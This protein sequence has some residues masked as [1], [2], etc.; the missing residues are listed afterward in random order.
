MSALACVRR[1]LKNSITASAS[2]CATIGTT[3]PRHQPAF[4]RRVAARP[5]V[6][7]REVGDPVRRAGVQCVA[8]ER[9]GQLMQAH[10]IRGGDE[11]REARRIGVVPER[12]AGRL[13][14]ARQDRDATE[15]PVQVGSE[16]VQRDVERL[17]RSAA[18]V[19][20]IGQSAQQPR[21]RMLA[22]ERRDVLGRLAVRV[23]E[24]VGV[25]TQHA[26]HGLERMRE[27]DQFAARPFARRLARIAARDR[28]GARGKALQRRAHRARERGAEHGRQRQRGQHDPG[29][30]P[31]GGF[32]RRMEVLVVR[33]DDQHCGGIRR[34]RQ[35]PHVAAVAHAR[36]R[37]RAGLGSK[38]DGVARGR[39]E[40]RI[41][42][43][44]RGLHARAVHERDVGVVRIGDAIELVDVEPALSHGNARDAIAR[45]PA[46][47]RE[48]HTVPVRPDERL[49]RVAG[50]EQ[51]ALDVIRRHGSRAAAY[52]ASHRPL[53]GRARGPGVATARD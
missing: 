40:R 18:A 21:A 37:R 24:P 14:L 46:R 6:Q 47:H 8:E 12:V 45:Q 32:E 22:R 48:S 5:V 42:P 53:Q 36:P 11:R 49:R 19:G 9:A 27:P 50:V 15:R 2:P 44:D 3:K 31:T 25:V 51:A 34:Q 1:S 20:G 23:L 33:H 26:G 35:R 43:A 28:I 39:G 52:A 13:G 7:A 10:R 16:L 30:A 17:A 41:G 38:P 29:C 4:V